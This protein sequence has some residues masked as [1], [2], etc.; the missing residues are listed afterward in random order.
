MAGIEFDRQA[1][2]PSTTPQGRSAIQLLIPLITV[3]AIGLVAYVGYKIY[4]VNE[5]NNE[6]IAVN[7]QVQQLEQQL[8]E[9]QKRIDSLER[10]RKAAMAEVNSPAP[11]STNTVSATANRNTRAEYRIDTASKF[12]AQTKVA[13][14]PQVQATP[15][16]SSSVFASEEIAGELAA[17]HTAWEA[18]TNRLA[19]VV[20]VVGT[21]QGE[22]SETRDAL[23]QLLA[24]THR[25]AISF[26]LDRGRSRVS[27]GPVSLQL[28]SADSKGQH[29]TVC[30]IFNKEKCI[31]LRDRA[32]NE[33]VVF[34]VAKNSPPL[35]L[36]ATKILRDQI[37]GYL[38]VP[39]AMQ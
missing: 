7:S 6:V 26:E 30:V 13:T 8:A 35:E 18:T 29:Y 28:K 32:L 22:L 27:V 25:K 39:S 23:N 16:V 34:V 20:G 19:D 10:H 3:S 12:P 31:E 15:S 38:E 14:P 24:Q 36:V 4:T 21:Q 37:T 1:F 11:S 2:I 5:H 9:M 33:V 17:N